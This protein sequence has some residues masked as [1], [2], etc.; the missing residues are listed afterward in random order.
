MKGSVEFPAEAFAPT[1]HVHIS[2]LP[3][4]VTWF[5]DL[6]KTTCIPLLRKGFS[7]SNDEC[8]NLRV[9]EA[10]VVRYDATP[11]NGPGK[12]GL[13]RHVDAADFL[14]SIALND[15]E[16]FEGGGMWVDALESVI[17][18]PAGTVIAID[19]RL[20]HAAMAVEK[21]SRFVLAVY[22]SRGVNRSGKAPGYT[23]EGLFKEGAP[24]NDDDNG[25]GGQ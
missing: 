10:I 17:S 4:V 23:L 13:K 22:V 11:E 1:V 19:P 7:L 12:R 9:I 2:S 6:F 18:G 3:A 8:K 15:P 24:P 21:G 14:L 5:N 20:P 25:G 16:D